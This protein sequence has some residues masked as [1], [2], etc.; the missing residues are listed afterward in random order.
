MLFVPFQNILYN[1]YIKD[2]MYILIKSGYIPNP[3][4]IADIA[5]P[6]Q[7]VQHNTKTKIILFM[8]YKS[9]N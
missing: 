6:K 7:N 1:I 3:T 9:T 8:I 5:V 4:N 2:P